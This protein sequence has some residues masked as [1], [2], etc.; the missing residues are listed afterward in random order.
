MAKKKTRKPQKTKAPQQSNAVKAREKAQSRRAFIQYG[1]AGGAVLVGGGYFG[2]TSLQASICEADLSKLDNGQ[3]TIVQI[4]DPSC[5]VCN[6]LQRET[7]KAIKDMSGA[8][9]QFLVANIKTLE[10]S[11]FAADHGVP[12][13]TL[14]MF[15]AKGEMIQVLRGPQERA[16]LTPLFEDHMARYARRS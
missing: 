13:I 16:V 11:S 1:V 9:P 6:A 14:L 2:V 10:G 4:H 15:D 12:N 7:R 8:K 3:P 5:P